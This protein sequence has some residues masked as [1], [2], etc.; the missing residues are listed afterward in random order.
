M[1]DRVVIAVVRITLPIT[2]QPNGV[3]SAVKTAVL[4]KFGT[5]SAL[6]TSK[7]KLIE[8]TVEGWT[9]FTFDRGCID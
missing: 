5:N 3:G 1:E 2:R 8:L 9:D 6:D 4:H 7:H